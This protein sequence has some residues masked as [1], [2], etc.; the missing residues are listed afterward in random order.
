MEISLEKAFKKGAFAR[1]QLSSKLPE[2]LLPRG[3]KLFL[4]SAFMMRLF[5]ALKINDPNKA[6]KKEHVPSK[7]II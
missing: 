4:E 5:G 1:S 2:L 3:Y 6:P 7:W